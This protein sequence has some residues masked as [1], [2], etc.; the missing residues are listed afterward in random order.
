MDALY[1]ACCGRPFKRASHRGPA[2]LYCSHDCR[3][4]M[5]VRRRAW[6][7][8]TTAAWAATRGE[9]RGNGYAKVAN[10]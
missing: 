6:A 9:G 4:Q 1:C 3:L 10:F 5:A 7:G 8:A 2:P